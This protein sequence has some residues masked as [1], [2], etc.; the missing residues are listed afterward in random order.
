MRASRA[1]RRTV[2]AAAR[3]VI[4]VV[5]CAAWHW[6]VSMAWMPVFRMVW[7]VEVPSPHRSTSTVSPSRTRTTLP[8]TEVLVWIQEAAAGDVAS[9][10]PTSARAAVVLTR[11]PLRDSAAWRRGERAAGRRA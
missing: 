9:M 8:S 3:E 10:T 11:R 7:G 2:F 5:A 6:P 1:V 4:S